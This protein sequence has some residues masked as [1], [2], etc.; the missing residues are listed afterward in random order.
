MRPLWSSVPAWTPIL[1][2]SGLLWLE[3]GAGL[4]QFTHTH[5]NLYIKTHT[6]HSWG[7]SL[8]T[9][10]T[11]LLPLQP[12]KSPCDTQKKRQ[13]LSMRGAQFQAAPPISVLL[14]A[15]P[16][17]FY[18][19]TPTG[20]RGRMKRGRRVEKKEEA[21]SKRWEEKEMGGRK[22]HLDSFIWWTMINGL[23]FSWSVLPQHSPWASSDKRVFE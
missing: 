12:D 7:H 3:P 10:Q 21:E 6:E 20:Q 4:L 14:Q 23:A 11:R 17:S 2:G 1:L 13:G 9:S 15:T 22:R 8:S 16:A 5:T 19:A 18:Y